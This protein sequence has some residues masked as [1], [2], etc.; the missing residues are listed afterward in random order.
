MKPQR[1][2]G[3]VAAADERVEFFTT[4]QYRCVL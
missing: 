3:C 4:K 2:W 1:L